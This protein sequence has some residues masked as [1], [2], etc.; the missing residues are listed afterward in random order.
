M[1][2]IQIPNNNDNTETD[3]DHK[4][5]CPPPLAAL[6]PKL[7]GHFSSQFLHLQENL[8]QLVPVPLQRN[9]RANMLLDDD[10]HRILFGTSCLTKFPHGCM[11]LLKQDTLSLAVV[12]EGVH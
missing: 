8:P 1:V 3:I 4:A 7:Y 2:G 12:V 11:L 10:R 5:E 9:L 6:F